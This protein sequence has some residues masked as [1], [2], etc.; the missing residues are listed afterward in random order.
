MTERSLAATALS[1]RAL[2]QTGTGLLGGAALSAALPAV[3]RA[4]EA[5]VGSWPAGVSGST[6]FV[7]ICLPRTGTYAGPGEDELKGFELAIEHINAGNALIR[8]IS[9]HTTK[10]VLGKQVTFGVADSEAKPNT[11]VQAQTRF[12]S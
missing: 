12:I 4:A 2:L 6:V 10:G 1:R 9:P 5:P 3:A 8:E 11:A 7:G